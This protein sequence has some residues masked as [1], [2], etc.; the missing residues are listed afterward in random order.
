ML[1]ALLTASSQDL[2]ETQHTRGGNGR[3][4]LAGE[5]AHTIACKQ[6]G[7]AGETDRQSE[8][9]GRDVVCSFAFLHWL[10][11]GRKV[12][13][14]DWRAAA[15]LSWMFLGTMTAGCCH[16]RLATHRDWARLLKHGMHAR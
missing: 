3:G 9:S 15:Q 7:L 13:T 1:A 16:A 6:S 12:S 4:Q 11:K 10:Q 2:Q 5:S 14:A 8:Q